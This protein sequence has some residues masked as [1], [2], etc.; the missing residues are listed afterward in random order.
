MPA[1]TPFQT[2]AQIQYGIEVIVILFRHCAQFQV[3]GVN[4]VQADNKF[5]TV[6]LIF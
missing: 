6:A 2:E 1:T 4:N 3:V 5:S